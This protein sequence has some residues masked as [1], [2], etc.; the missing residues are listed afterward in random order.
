M[1]FICMVD[2]D[3]YC[4]KNRMESELVERIGRD[5][6]QKLDHV[7]VGDLDEEISKYDQLAKLQAHHLMV[8]SGF[9]TLLWQDLQA[10]NQ[11]LTTKKRVNC[12]VYFTAVL[13][14]AVIIV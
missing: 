14:T 1:Y 5:V 8:G 11:R 7:Y 4:V 3:F 6:L 2:H 9:N 10:T 12:G 13:E